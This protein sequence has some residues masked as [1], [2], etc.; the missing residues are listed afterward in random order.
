MGL[1]L[2]RYHCSMTLGEGYSELRNPNLGNLFKKFEII[3]QW[4]TGFK[5]IKKELVNYPEINLLFDDDSSYTQ[6]KF[7]KITTTQETTRDKIIELLKD[8]PKY[9]KRDLMSALGKADST[10]KEH[11]SKLKKEG[12][13]QR[14][15]STKSGY[16]KVK[17]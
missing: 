6:M 1:K 13:L 2:S 12:V 10:I 5:K 9:T 7:V 15:G 14:I 16:W 17:E 11:L 3:E 4:G 8:N